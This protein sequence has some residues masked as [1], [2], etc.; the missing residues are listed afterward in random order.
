MKSL[1]PPEY[2]GSLNDIT[3]NPIGGGSNPTFASMIKFTAMMP[4]D[5]IFCPSLQCAVYDSILF[6]LSQPLIGNLFFPLGLVYQVQKALRKNEQE[7]EKWFWS[8]LNNEQ[9]LLLEQPSETSFRDLLG[10]EAQSNRPASIVI[11]L[12]YTFRMR[13]N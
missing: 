11:F 9:S 13:R 4:S 3:T 5:E 1:A 6:G 8:A 10:T 7:F 2:Q 12:L